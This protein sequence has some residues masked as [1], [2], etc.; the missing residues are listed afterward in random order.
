MVKN[1]IPLGDILSGRL[2]QREGS[3]LNRSLNMRN[4]KIN[5]KIICIDDSLQD[6]I[7]DNIKNNILYVVRGDD[8]TGGPYLVGI[9]AGF[10]NGVER[11]WNPSRF[12]TLE[13]IKKENKEKN[14]SVEV[15]K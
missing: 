12:K 11:G 5:D 15:I 8:G 1:V 4:F 13:E 3:R 14:L 9:C 7:G 10:L 2:N 6:S